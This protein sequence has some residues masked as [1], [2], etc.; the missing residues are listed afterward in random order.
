MQPTISEF[1]Q[2][3]ERHFAAV[4]IAANSGVE[5]LFNIP[6]VV[7]DKCGQM[8]QLRSTIIRPLSGF[9]EI[10]EPLSALL[11]DGDTK[12]SSKSSAAKAFWLQRWQHWVTQHYAST[13]SLVMSMTFSGR[14]SKISLLDGFAAVVFLEFG[15]V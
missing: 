7:R 5:F 1:G 6:A 13:F 2:N 10:L 11:L 3:V 4:L 8:A 14:R 15:S 9:V 12:F